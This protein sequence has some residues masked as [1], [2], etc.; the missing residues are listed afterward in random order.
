MDDA[1]DEMSDREETIS[2]QLVRRGS[3]GRPVRH[4]FIDPGLVIATR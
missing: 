4:T 1:A 3:A 2:V